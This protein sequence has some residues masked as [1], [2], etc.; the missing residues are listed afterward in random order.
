MDITPFFVEM[1][2]NSIRNMAGLEIKPDNIIRGI[3]GITE[4]NS[5]FSMEG[6]LGR[7]FARG[8]YPGTTTKGLEIS[9]VIL[10]FGTT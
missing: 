10:V 6:E 8:V 4:K 7:A 9:E 5:S 1:D 3:G 2:M